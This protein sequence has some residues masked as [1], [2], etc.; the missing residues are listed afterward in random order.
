MMAEGVA[1]LLFGGFLFAMGWMSS[2][3]ALSKELNQRHAEFRAHYRQGVSYLIQNQPDRALD[4]FLDHLAVNP[5]SLELYMALGG[6]YRRKGEVDRAIRLHQSLLDLSQDRVADDCVGQNKLSLAQR[7]DV[8]LALAED[9][10][11]AGL[12]DRAED[13]L[14]DLLHNTASLPADVQERA[15]R[16]LQNIYEKEKEWQH[17]IQVAKQLLQLGFSEMSQVLAHYRCELAELAGTDQRYLDAEQ[18]FEQALKLDG[19][20]VRAFVGLG[21]LAYDSRDYRRALKFLQRLE[22]E[23]LYYFPAAVDMLESSYNALGREKA[24]WQYLEDALF[25]SSALSQF[26]G[27]IDAWYQQLKQQVE[28]G[29]VPYTC[30]HCGFTGKSLYWR[31]PSCNKWGGF[32][33]KLSPHA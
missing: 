1:W 16:Y 31:C 29:G 11:S 26:S 7:Q 33:P 17:A 15:L 10:Y 18:H 14:R 24:F 28:Q 22:A 12:L 32:K 19:T 8:Q 30:K 5:D 9:Y 2:R 6:V 25:Q 27:K 3:R 20:S 21:Q 23:H 4:V 13:I